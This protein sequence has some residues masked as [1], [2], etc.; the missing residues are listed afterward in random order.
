MSRLLLAAAVTL[1]GC[2]STIPAQDCTQ[3]LAAANAATVQAQHDFERFQGTG[4]WIYQGQG[5]QYD[6]YASQER[7]AYGACQR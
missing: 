6:A 3:Y 5:Q 4:N 1:A 7:R 2:G